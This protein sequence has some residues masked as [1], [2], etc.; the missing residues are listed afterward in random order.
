MDIFAYPSDIS[1]PGGAKHPLYDHG[2]RVVREETEEEAKEAFLADE[3]MVKKLKDHN[4]TQ[5]VTHIA[6][7]AT[8]S[9]RRDLSRRSE[10][11]DDA[12]PIQMAFEYAIL[13]P[14]IST[15]KKKRLR[16]KN[17]NHKNTT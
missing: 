12:R 17:E 5:L 1:W 2:F 9:F 11:R 3:D 4:I 6:I 10:R 8:E 14:H 15:L 7:P 13:A 16:N